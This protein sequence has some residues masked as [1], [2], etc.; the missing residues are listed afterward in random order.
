MFIHH[1]F[2]PISFISTSHPP[3]RAKLINLVDDYFHLH[4]PTF[5]VE[6]P[7]SPH[8]PLTYNGMLKKAISTKPQEQ[9]HK[10]LILTAK[11]LS[12]TTLIIPFIMLLAKYLLRQPYTF[13]PL[14]QDHTSS[15]E[16]ANPT[17]FANSLSMPTEFVKTQ[18]L[19]TITSIL[20]TSIPLVIT[21][22]VNKNIF[23][24]CKSSKGIHDF[25]LNSAPNFVFKIADDN[26]YAQTIFANTQRIENLIKAKGYNKVFVPKSQ[27]LKITLPNNTTKFCIIKEKLSFPEEHKKNYLGWSIIPEAYGW[28][29]HDEELRPAIAQTA[30]IIQESGLSDVY[31]RN[32]P[33][34]LHNGEW[35]ICLLGTED[36]RPSPAM[37]R[38]N[39]LQLIQCA[40][41]EKS[42]QA[43]I[44][45]CNPA[46]IS[47]NNIQS[48]LNDLQNKKIKRSEEILNILLYKNDYKKMQTS[49]GHINNPFKPIIIDIESLKLDL[50]QTALS[51]NQENIAIKDVINTVI[52]L[53]NKQLSI[54]SIE[55]FHQYDNHQYDN[56]RLINFPLVTY[57]KKEKDYIPHPSISGYLSDTELPL[58]HLLGLTSKEISD[59]K[60]LIALRKNQGKHTQAQHNK[61]L[62]YQKKT[63]LYQIFTAL[64]ENGYIFSSPYNGPEGIKLLLSPEFKIK[65]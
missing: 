53:L 41:S 12:Y 29:E 34:V 44:D 11:I 28:L 51:P 15:T 14:L 58:L 7:S 47:Q 42:I 10:I 64:Q 25:E 18:D 65:M 8:N 52:T 54:K 19:K 45:S 40:F 6:Q 2:T 39:L 21:K 60:A 46:L 43:I 22:P 3:L 59:F 1:F 27:L 50:T 36:F 9:A 35:K 38:Y 57:S 48:L 32:T 23:S 31:Y 24:S 56:H 62:E 30:S 49:L 13:V 37:I 16:T 55:P 61:A 33:A 17:G 26:E 5:I 20:S 4:G 63:W